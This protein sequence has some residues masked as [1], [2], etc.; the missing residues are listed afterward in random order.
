MELDPVH[1]R[2]L[3]DRPRMRGAVAQSLAVRLAGSPDVRFGDRSKRDKL[4]GIDFDQ[5][6]AHWVAAALLD[7]WPPPQPD[8]QRDVAGQDVVAQ[9]AAELHIPDASW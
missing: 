2:V 9:L 1:E 5:T 7:L 3:I 8:R 6:G 4:E